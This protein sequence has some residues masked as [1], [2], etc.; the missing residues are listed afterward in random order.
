MTLIEIMVTIAI[1][2][3]IVVATAVA[4][5]GIFSAR[6]DASSNKLSGMVRYAYNLAALNGQV[7][8]VVVDITAGTYHIEEMPE[9]QECSRLEEGL[10]EESSDKNE[11]EE[12][13]PAGTKV[14]DMRVR[15]EKLPGGIQFVGA[16]TRHNKAVT[17][18]GT[19]SIYF[20]PDGTAEKA[21]V[22][23]SDGN[24]VFTVEVTALMGT[25]IV[26]SEELDYQ[27]LKKR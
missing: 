3:L 14:E 16:F 18:E 15:T 21:F 1:I 23:L 8:R 22:W 9:R 11:E 19:E 24:E 25:G 12:D 13:E 17:E 27:E 20:F 2:G 6:L 10:E 5:G 4:V 7:Y 26:H